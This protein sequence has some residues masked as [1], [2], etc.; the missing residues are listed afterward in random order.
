M[1]C[2]GNGRMQ[3]A[4][5]SVA[6]SAAPSVRRDAVLQSR[7]MLARIGT[8]HV[9]A[10]FMGLDIVRHRRAR[11]VTVTAAACCIY[12]AFLNRCSP[13]PKASLCPSQ[14]RVVAPPQHYPTAARVKPRVL[15]KSRSQRQ[16]KPTSR[17]PGQYL[18]K[19]HLAVLDVLALALVNLV[20][21]VPESAI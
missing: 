15:C 19:L 17:Q 21:P 10:R 18:P 13:R 9:C 6:L 14:R 16:K 12:R 8:R 3:A 11:P 4:I 7:R 2:G 1:G 20:V 5:D